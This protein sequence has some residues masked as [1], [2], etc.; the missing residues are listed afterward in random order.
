MK[1]LIIILG[2]LFFFIACNKE[3]DG[4]LKPTDTHRDWF[5]VYDDPNDPLKHEIFLI[6][7]AFK[8]PIFI[9]DTIGEEERVD[10]YGNPYTHY[11][12]L[13]VLYKINGGE[14]YLSDTCI[15]TRNTTD[16]MNGVKLI[17]E[18]VLPLIPFRIAPMSYFI[19]EELYAHSLE[20]GRYFSGMQTTVIANLS[21][22]KDMS[23]EEWKDLGTEI[24]S[25]DFAQYVMEE[26]ER[27]L[28]PFY[29][30]SNDVYGHS[31]YDRTL[32]A[33]GNPPVLSTPTEEYGMLMLDGKSTLT[34]EQ[35]I[36]QFIKQVL[37]GDKNAFMEK[38]KEWPL[39]KQKYEIME[40]LM[41]K[42]LKEI[43][44]TEKK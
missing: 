10:P 30:V 32:L 29:K 14:T 2:C 3:E 22:L 8:V 28:L 19:V 38:Y 40:T 20:K 44:N 35:D 21:Y 18:Y 43:E 26:C 37:L 17:K 41:N 4:K 6:Y 23:Q 13:D 5:V 15:E 34:Q 24:A 7:E 31:V 25:V 33:T 9:D 16:L 42:A 11:E 12:V 36:I 27:E 39:V 1:D